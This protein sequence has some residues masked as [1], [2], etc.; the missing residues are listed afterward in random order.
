MGGALGF[1]ERPGSPVLPP[2]PREI[3]EQRGA[4]GRKEL[5]VS[6]CSPDCWPHTGVIPNSRALGVLRQTPGR[7][8]TPPVYFSQASRRALL[9]SPR[10][11]L[12]GRDVLP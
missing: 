11:L 4:W 3:E 5:E 2:R 8:L 7:G 1:L 10:A 6:Q 12:K 9:P